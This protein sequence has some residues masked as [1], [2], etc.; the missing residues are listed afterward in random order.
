MGT[1]VLAPATAPTALTPGR[2][3]FVTFVLAAACGLTVANL[4]YAQ[5]LLTLI[6]TSLHVG[7]GAATIVVTLTQIG[8]AL[9]LIFVLPLGDLFENRALTSRLL[10]GTTLAL[11]LAAFSPVFGVFLAAAVLIGLTSCVAQILVPLAAHLAPP[12]SSGRVVGRVMSGLLLG[13]LL[14]RT[15]ASLVAAA[16]G[17]RTIY[18]I[19]A[20]LMLCLAVVL[21]RTLPVRRPDTGRSYPRLLAS[22][23]ELARTEPVLRRRAICQATM[24]GAFSV[25]WTVITFQLIDQHHFTQ[26]QVGLFALVGAAGAA[27]APLGGRLAD[28]G[29]GRSGSGAALLLG[30]AALVVA[31]LGHASVILLAVGAVLLDLAVQCHGVM[32]QHE[33]YGLRSTARARINTV[34]MGTTFVGGALGSA[35]AGALNTAYGW[36]AATAF[37]AV[38]P[39]LGFVVWLFGS[40]SARHS[41]AR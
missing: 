10:V 31:C 12:A 4:Y 19:S 38:L 22:V 13:I 7:Q 25:F 2:L 32:S 6:A 34:F 24:F 9:G 40:R 18:L 23:V 35:C 26:S 1:A 36:T 5:P 29:H 15:V 3:R 17:W 11:L 28:R 30:S 41:A 16:W 21:R 39:L 33:I 14:A 20:V 27:A 8:Y 37:G